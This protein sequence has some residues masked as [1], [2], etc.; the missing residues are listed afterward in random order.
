MMIT[1]NLGR[2]SDLGEFCFA[3]LRRNA[4]MNEPTV[5]AI[6][7]ASKR[8]RLRFGMRSLLGIVLFLGLV[9]GWLT[10]MQRQ[11][12][13]REASVTDLANDWVHAESRDPTLSWRAISMVLRE[14]TVLIDTQISL[15]K[16]LGL[17]WLSY[18]VSFSA[19]NSLSDEA[20]PGV[21]KRLQL[22]GDV[23]EVQFHGGW[24]NGTRFFYLGTIPYD[25]L[26]PERETCTFRAYPASPA[27][28]MVW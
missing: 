6:V 21:M 24:Q 20:V 16:W 28:R 15:G 17:G 3:A 2:R 9:F 12:I 1:S 18:P 11:A 19:D 13:E 5:Q 26:G 4:V 27:L 23:Y 7:S 25:R 10:R 22:L 14:R 8:R